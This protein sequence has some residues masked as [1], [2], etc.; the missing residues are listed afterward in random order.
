[1][2]EQQ[3]KKSALTAALV[4]GAD[5]PSDPSAA[6][7]ADTFAFPCL[8]DVASAVDEVA[9]SVEKLPRSSLAGSAP[10]AQRLAGT[11]TVSAHPTRRGRPRRTRIRGLGFVHLWAPAG[12]R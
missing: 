10:T 4:G 6:S 11:F 7:K 9:A 5:T 12:V 3:K 8:G 1:M 2:A